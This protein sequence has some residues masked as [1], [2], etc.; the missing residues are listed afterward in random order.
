MWVRG[1]VRALR[2][3]PAE[4]PRAAEQQPADDDEQERSARHAAALNLQNVPE[5]GAQRRPAPHLTKQRRCHPLG[6]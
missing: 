6:A 4:R 2:L 3:D 5:D 1:R